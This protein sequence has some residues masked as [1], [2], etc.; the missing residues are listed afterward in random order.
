MNIPPIVGLVV[1]LSLGLVLGSFSMYQYMDK[2]QAHANAE[3]IEQD[4]E[5]AADIT[6]V[7][8]A[9][10]QTNTVAKTI[11]K[12]RDRPPVVITQELTADEINTVCNNHFAPADIVQSLRAEAR[13]AWARFNDLPDDPVP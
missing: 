8:V 5:T 1:S 4:N 6:A 2:E 12:W 13:R 3:Q 9:A 11:T 10:K 7:T